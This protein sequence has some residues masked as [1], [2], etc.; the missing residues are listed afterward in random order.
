[1]QQLQL[2]YTSLTQFVASFPGLQLV[3]SVIQHWV[4]DCDGSN[5]PIKIG[6]DSLSTNLG[7]TKTE[8]CHYSFCYK[9][10]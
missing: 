4:L 6:E 2:L 3:A 7:E 5:Q 8:V 1:M 10:T 9:L